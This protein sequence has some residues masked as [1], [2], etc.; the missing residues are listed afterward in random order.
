MLYLTTLVKKTLNLWIYPVKSKMVFLIRNVNVRD[1]NTFQYA[2]EMEQPG[3]NRSDTGHISIT[4]TP[5]K[6]WNA[7]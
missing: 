6:N 2:V 4:K 5:L 7:T 1:L 3:V